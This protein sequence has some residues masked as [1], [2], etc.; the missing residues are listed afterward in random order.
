[1]RTIDD[2]QVYRRL[3]AL[4]AEL[5]RIAGETI[6]PRSETALRA[7]AKVIRRLASALFKASN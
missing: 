6:S 5:L 2:N 1:M 4:E 7:A 3:I